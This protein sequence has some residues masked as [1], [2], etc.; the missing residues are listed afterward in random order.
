MLSPQAKPLAGLGLTTGLLLTLLCPW[1]TLVTTPPLM[2]LR[3][4]GLVRSPPAP[5]TVDHP[6]RRPKN[7]PPPRRSTVA[8]FRFTLLPALTT[9][10]APSAAVTLVAV[11][12]AVP[13]PKL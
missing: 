4:F 6:S 3:G 7:V 1:R 9:I 2:P 8:L 12:F 13:D 10:A 11:E 5:L